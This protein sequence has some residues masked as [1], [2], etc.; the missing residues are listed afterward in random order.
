M[1]PKGQYFVRVTSKN[2]SGKTQYAF[3]YYVTDIGKNYGVRCFYIDGSGKIMED[4]DVE[5]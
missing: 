4:A 1:L 3:D 5:T 2:K